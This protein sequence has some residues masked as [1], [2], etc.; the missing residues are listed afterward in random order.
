M[1]HMPWIVCLSIYLNVGTICVTDAFKDIQAF[2][3]G[4]LLQSSLDV[5]FF[6]RILFEMY[7]SERY[8][9][10]FSFVMDSIDAIP[11]H[12]STT[13]VPVTLPINPMRWNMLLGRTKSKLASSNKS[14]PQ[15]GCLF[16]FVKTI[17]IKKR[18]GSTIS[19]GPSWRQSMRTNFDSTLK[20]L[21]RS[22]DR[23]LK[24]TDKRMVYIYGNKFFAKKDFTFGLR[25]VKS[26]VIHL[27]PTTHV[28]MLIYELPASSLKSAEPNPM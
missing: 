11:E 18:R 3:N 27:I 8:F 16:C 6:T 15:N 20:G 12:I 21:L 4:S 25:M 17:G 13:V 1:V 23:L 5:P 7:K 26:G 2:I 24:N 14:L 9:E 10:H 28:P 19:N 22:S